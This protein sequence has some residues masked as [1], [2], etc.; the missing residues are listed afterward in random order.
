VVR[1]TD[2]DKTHLRSFPADKLDDYEKLA[3]MQPAGVKYEILH[4]PS[5]H[6]I[7]IDPELAR[8]AKRGF[9]LPK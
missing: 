4:R 9:P 6:A 3:E 5:I 1:V 8:A 7:E 2:G